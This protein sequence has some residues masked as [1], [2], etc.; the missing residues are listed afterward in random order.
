MIRFI[1]SSS[2]TI[3]FK[4]GYWKNLSFEMS[5][6]KIENKRPKLCEIHARFENRRITNEKVRHNFIKISWFIKS[7]MKSNITTNI[8]WVR[9]AVKRTESCNCLKKLLSDL[10]FH[11]EMSIFGLGSGREKK[12]NAFIRSEIILHPEHNGTLEDFAKC[13]SNYYWFECSGGINCFA[14]SDGSEWV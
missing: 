6:F 13:C 14:I 2:K 5:N 9:D 1:N 8:S 4:T 11:F 3:F 12:N 7:K 10:K